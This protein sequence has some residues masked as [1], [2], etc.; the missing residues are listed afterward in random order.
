MINMKYFS[1]QFFLTIATLLLLPISHAAAAHV[2]LSVVGS[3]TIGVPLLID[4]LVDPE[5]ESIN[6]ADIT[7]SFDADRYDF[8]GYVEGDGAIGWWVATPHEFEPG[9]VQFSG[10]I[11][12][13]IERLY[14]SH[15]PEM[16]AVPVA[17]L[18]F[19]P[20]ENG[21]ASFT[22]VHAK[23]LRNDGTGSS[24]SARTSGVRVAAKTA[25]VP[26]A[27]APIDETPPLPFSITLVED[28]TFGKSPRLAV[29]DARDE[30]S[31][32]R[33]YEVRINGGHSREVQS[34]YVLPRRLFPYTLT[35]RAI[36][37]SGN[38]RDA[39][40]T[41]QGR[42]SVPALAIAAVVLLGIVWYMRRTRRRMKFK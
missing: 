22:V 34:P 27:T 14:D 5:G 4:V 30:E 8:S 36:D 39:E 12:G 24:L 16:L 25:T 41:V 29:F 21:N 9:R 38:Y 15:A 19:T 7:V 33:T 3:A 26:L 17:R 13:G 35:A 42:G 20:R 11:L 40:I 32:I 18:R 31:G 10:V 1:L 23:L 28:S 37:F 6:S 2:S